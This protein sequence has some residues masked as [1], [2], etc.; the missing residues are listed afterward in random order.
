MTKYADNS[1][2]AL[3]IGFANEMGAICQAYGVDSHAVM[4]VFASDTK[5]N[6]STR[7]PQARASR[8]AARACPRTCARSSTT[9]AAPTSRCRSSRT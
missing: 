5:L 4:E 7:L 2:H 6:I 9:R 1:F 8:S 3:K